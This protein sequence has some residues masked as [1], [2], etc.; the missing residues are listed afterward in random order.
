MVSSTRT[1][2]AS[3]VDVAAVPAD[4]D[5][6]NVAF[7]GK[8]A[9]VNDEH[10]VDKVYKREIVWQNVAKFVWLHA[11]ALSGV[12]CLFMTASWATIGF[13]LL[14]YVVSGVVS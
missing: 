4:K 3:A 10:K 9:S 8:A 2:M 11:L 1:V 13:S 7:R 5:G 12:Y 6:N 14:C